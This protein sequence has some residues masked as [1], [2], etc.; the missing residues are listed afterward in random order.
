MNAAKAY[1][2]AIIAAL[3]SVLANGQNV[4]PWWVVLIIGGVVAGLATYITPNRP[5]RKP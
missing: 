4:L 1:I 3:T 5:A 2:A